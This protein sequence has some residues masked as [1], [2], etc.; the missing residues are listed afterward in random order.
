M[1]NL[2]TLID[3]YSTDA[4]CRELLE[5]LRWPNG[6]ACIRCGSMGI[7]EI[8]SR[9]QY[10]CNDCRYQFS[11]TVGTIMHDSHLPLRKWFLA[12]YLMCESKKGISALQLKRTLGVAYKT[13][14]YLCHRIREAMGNDPFDGPTLLGI[15][16]VD[17][18]LV[19][20]KTKG[21]GRAY[22]GN[23]TLVAGAIQR[24]GSIRLERIPDTKRQ[25]LHDF[26]ART[27]KDE[28]EAIYTDELAS[29][30]GIEDHNTRH[31]TVNHSIE[32]WAVGDVHTNSIEGVWSLFKRSIIGAFHKVSA[33]HID[34][35]LDELEWRFSNRG[36][37]HI[38]VHTLR[39]IVNT[40]HLTYQA[41]VA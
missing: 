15:V 2:L 8:E 36:N 16:E 14:W 17:E 27:V 37:D 1:T 40:E 6:V 13:A 25:T 3:D 33:K 24:N 10:D 7:S 35:Y 23:K 18:T 19:G 39:R 34:R 31:E 22:K 11:V 21:K 29:Y 4:K 12:I 5:R 32:E 9:N 30:L 20:G 38:F 41:L 28:A 26:I